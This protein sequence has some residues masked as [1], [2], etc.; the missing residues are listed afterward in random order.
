MNLSVITAVLV[1]S[2]IFMSS[3]RAQVLFDPDFTT[4]TTPS[5]YTSS[6]GTAGSLTYAS[7]TMT[8]SD[9]SVKPTGAAPSGG[10]AY[11]S[12]Q[13]STGPLSNTI[14]TS[15]TFTPTYTITGTSGGQTDISVLSLISENSNNN[16][17]NIAL[18]ATTFEGRA[19]IVMTSGIAFGGGS[20]TGTTTIN[21]TSG[22]DGFSG[23]T[24][25][26]NDIMTSTESSGNVWS[27][28]N[29]GSLYNGTTLL[30]NFNYTT[31]GAAGSSFD[32]INN[33]LTLTTGINPNLRVDYQGLIGSGANV[34]IS[35]VT[36]EVVPE[37]STYALLLGGVVSLFCL[38]YRRKAVSLR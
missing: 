26:V 30:G 6:T 25:T 31:T 4:G 33:K 32:P 27:I 38:A 3:A 17:L 13:T 22:I 18:E 12:S 36:V 15:I 7:G 14:A 2:G 24:L 37:P 10:E 29:V 9:F 23:L 16:L 21:S 35:N 11:I 20:T 8:A 19:S 5:G 34:Q 1:A 28:N